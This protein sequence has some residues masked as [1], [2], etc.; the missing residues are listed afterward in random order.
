MAALGMLN[1]RVTPV[2]VVVALGLYAVAIHRTWHKGGD[3]FLV[4]VGGVLLCAIVVR[5][6]IP[7][8]IHVTS[9]PAINVLYMSP[10]YPLMLALVGLMFTQR[11]WR[12]PPGSGVGGA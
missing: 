1:A 10:L 11:V 8:V 6:L 9:F 7:A 12:E 5:L 2:L 4:L 3:L